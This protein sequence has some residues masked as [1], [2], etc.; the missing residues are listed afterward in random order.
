MLKRLLPARKPFF[1]AALLLIALPAAASAQNRLLVTGAGVMRGEDGRDSTL[2]ILAFPKSFTGGVRVATGDVN[3]DG[4]PDFVAAP[5]P[6]AG[7]HVHVFDGASLRRMRSRMSS[8]VA[9][10]ASFFGGVYVAAGDVNGD[11]VADIITGPGE[12]APPDVRVFDAVTGRTLSSFMAYEPSFRGGVRV[13][14]GDVDG[15]GVAEIVTG[16]G[17]GGGPHVK[18]FNAGGRTL[19]DFFAAG[20]SST[21]GVFVAAGDVNGDGRADIVTGAGEGGMPLVQVF[22]P[23]DGLNLLHNFFAFDP[24]FTG[25][26]RVAAGDVNGDNVDDVVAGA[27]PGGAPQVRVF[28]PTK[29]RAL[30]HDFSAYAPDYRGGVYVGGFPAQRRR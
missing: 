25:G 8:F 12:G 28:D 9:Y 15:D 13:A 22:D 2:S 17:P 24:S 30:L 7:P 1:H 26:V 20:I 11:G 16:A 21:G 23:S 29:G 27:G 10:N 14:V 19:H 6:G 3:G 5:G 4:E 18:V